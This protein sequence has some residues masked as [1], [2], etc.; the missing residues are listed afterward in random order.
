MKRASLV[1][2]LFAFVL[3][4][5]GLCWHMAARGLPAWPGDTVIPLTGLFHPRAADP[6]VLAISAGILL[7]G[8]LPAMRV[9]LVL[10]IYAG[11]RRWADVVLAGI[12][13]LE[14]AASLI[15]VGR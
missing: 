1:V 13:V 4:V 7:L 2:S 6:A 12:V 9:I 10:G 3:M 11:R 5:G 15:G 8:F 14:L